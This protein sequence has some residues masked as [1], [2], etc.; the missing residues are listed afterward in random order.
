VKPEGALGSRETLD[1]KLDVVF[2]MLF[3][4]PENRHLLVSLLDAVLSP[5]SPIRSLEVE[6]ELAKGA[7]DD[8]GIALDIRI[9]LEDG[10]QVD[11]EMQTQPRLAR[12]ER[13]LYYW[14]RM[15][16]GQLGRGEGYTAL[17]RCVVVLILAFNELSS[18]RFHSIFRVREV[19]DHEEL[20]DQLE[21]HLVELPKLT[22][23]SKN[24]EPGLVGWGRFLSAKTDD[25]LEQLAM[26][27]PVL[28]QAKAALER[29]STDPE[30]RVLAE[31]RDMA[32][33]SYELD[34]GKAHAQGRAEGRTEG[35]AEG[36]TEGRAEG[37][38]TAVLTLLEARGKNLAPEQRARIAGCR[39]LSLLDRWLRKA[40]AL[41]DVS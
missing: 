36:R 15:Y 16:A 41:D 37:T 3:G 24:D 23:A 11:V 7:V 19:H 14:A 39:D 40:V 10:Q 22:A 31:Q 25:D 18:D 34:L 26:T 35:R 20:S 9:E 1:P 33:K 27:D 6:S 4:R 5:R 29:L 21:L 30:A 12:R 38:A 17:C 32:L 2:K 28:R 13:A 8:K